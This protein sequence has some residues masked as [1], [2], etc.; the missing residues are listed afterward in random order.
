MC[1]LD[2]VIPA[3]AQVVIFVATKHHVEYVHL[4]CYYFLYFITEYVEVESRCC[5]V[6]GSFREKEQIL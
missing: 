3:M 6:L 5:V 4:V 2:H 1:L